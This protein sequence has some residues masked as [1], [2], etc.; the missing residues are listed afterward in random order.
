MVRMLLLSH[1]E[2]S[3]EI[4]NTLELVYG[5]MKKV[6]YIIMEEGQDMGEYREKISSYIQEEQLPVIIFVDL[7]GG[8][9]F[10]TAT[11]VCK[12]QILDKKVE[13]I[14]GMNL[15]MLLESLSHVDD[16][17]IDIE[18]MINIAM[19]AGNMGIKRLGNILKGE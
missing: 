2:L 12:D 8:S 15:P 18:K 6:H 17:D 11:N 19:E 3:K 9:P 4:Y 10:L 16:E 14:T 7:L 5:K 1:G 13:I